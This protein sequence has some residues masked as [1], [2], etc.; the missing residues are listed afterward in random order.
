MMFTQQA[1]PANAD[2]NVC[3]IRIYPLARLFWLVPWLWV[4]SGQEGRQLA[5]TGGWC[6]LLTME[7]RLCLA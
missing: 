7:T 5:D 1:A 3:C 4:L 6:Q 2:S